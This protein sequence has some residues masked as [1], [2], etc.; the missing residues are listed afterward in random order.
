M[1]IPAFS[2]RPS[3]SE[4]IDNTFYLLP[5]GLSHQCF[6]TQSLLESIEHALKGAIGPAGGA[7]RAAMVKRYLTGQDGALACERMADVLER[8]ADNG[9]APAAPSFARKLSGLLMAEGRVLIKRVKSYIPGS[10]APPE[11]HR[12]RYP[13]ITLEELRRRIRRFQEILKDDTPLSA[14]AMTPHVF[15]IRPDR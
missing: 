9:P 3:V 2:F 15:R 8:I 10:H 5:H 13:G 12:H 7:E 6:T 11:F 1:R 4:A 14:E